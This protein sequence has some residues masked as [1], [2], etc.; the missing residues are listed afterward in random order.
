M[1]NIKAAEILKLVASVLICLIA[2]FVG[3]AA[4]MPSI[5]TWYASLIKPAW[6]PPNWLFGPVWTTL[7]ILMGIAAFLVWREG[8]RRKEVKIAL[9]IFGVQLILNVLWSIVFFAFKS[10]LGGFI[11]IVMLWVTILITIIAFYRISKPAGIILIPYIAWVSIASALN[12]TV[13]LLNI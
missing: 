6:T 4:T 1:V 13:Y 11:I 10:T 12:Y 3:S 5:T 2:G 7:Y 9:G 8:L